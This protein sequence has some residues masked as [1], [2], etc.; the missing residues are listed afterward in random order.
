MARD[1]TN[2]R[3]FDDQF[4][5]AQK[6]DA[7]GRL[8]GGVAHDFNNLLSIIISAGAMLHEDLP[9]D[10]PLQPMTEEIRIACR[11]AADLTRQLLA[12][13]R[14]QMLVPAPLSVNAIVLAA[15]EE[16]KSKVGAAI[17]VVTQLDPKVGLINA[18]GA[19]IERVVV[20]LCLNAI[21]AMPAG[22][23][24]TFSTCDVSVSASDLDA[25]ADTTPG[26]YVRLRVE[27]TGIGMNAVTRSH[28][29]EPFFTTK[30]RGKGVGLGLATAYGVVRQ[31][32][33]HIRVRSGEGEGTAFS[34]MFPRLGPQPVSAAVVA[35]PASMLPGVPVAGRTGETIL[36]VEDDSAVRR[37]AATLLTKIGYR[38]IQADGGKE[39]L[40]VSDVELAT[41]HLLLTDVMMPG[42]AGP[43]I[44]TALTSRRPGL[45]VLFMSG[46]NAE[47]VHNVMR[48]PFT[49]DTLSRRVREMLDQPPG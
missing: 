46:Y 36:L 7:V 25:A 31:S 2:K 47:S 22:G 26:E 13:S 5:H 15:L 30:P 20:N 39:A 38:V 41:V 12:F 45:R 49:L 24:L 9:A 28:L 6:M 37:V 23:A 19:Q 42:M 18:D 4:L 33:G 48:K 27:D 21:E 34:L 40:A 17:K 8:A 3:K 35:R 29:F 1:I 11:R 10:H 16:M 14:R 32:N 44:A 43:E